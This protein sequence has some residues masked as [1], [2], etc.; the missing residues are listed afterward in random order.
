MLSLYNYVSLE[1]SLYL[2]AI[3]FAIF[4]WNCLKP[5]R[6]KYKI[7][8]KDKVTAVIAA[9]LQNE[10]TII[11]DTVRC[12]LQ[13]KNINKVILVWNGPKPKDENLLNKLEEI[14]SEHE[15]KLEIIKVEGS[16][17][18]AENLNYVFTNRDFNYYALFD[19][20]SRPKKNAVSKALELFDSNSIGW[21]NIL[22]SSNKNSKHMIINYLDKVECDY[23]NSMFKILDS[24]KMPSILIGHDIVI[25]KNILD[26]RLLGNYL[27]EDVEF[28]TRN[29]IESFRSRSTKDILSYSSPPP[30]YNSLYKQRKRWSMGGIELIFIPFRNYNFDS[31]TITFYLMQIIFIITLPPF[32]PQLL[33]FCYTGYSPLKIFN[34]T[35]GL[36]INTFLSIF[37]GIVYMFNGKPK[38]EVTKRK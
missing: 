19:A 9:Y 38:W 14:S 28:G 8:P 29:S 7:L 21:V 13:L 30:D 26:N 5:N 18:K 1:I 31:K 6:S 25:S 20:D 11:E 35:L 16:T 24:F 27:I 36:F 37:F 10:E 12:I 17:S 23:V 2:F 15:N 32:L 4:L 34:F 22:F 33:L 3:F